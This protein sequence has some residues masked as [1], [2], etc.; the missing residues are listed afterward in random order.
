[1]ISHTE[2]KLIRI[3]HTWPH[4]KRKALS[5]GGRKQMAPISGYKEE[6]KKVWSQKVIMCHRTLRK[7]WKEA[8]VNLARLHVLLD[9]TKFVTFKVNLRKF[10]P[11]S[12]S[13]ASFLG[14][15]KW[16]E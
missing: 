14:G 13:L 8:S 10:H 1:M 12:S 6:A 2:L 9:E 11:N 16:A 4:P 7:E 5:V 3:R 15:N